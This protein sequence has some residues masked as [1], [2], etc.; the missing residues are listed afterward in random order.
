MEEV[1]DEMAD[2][3]CVSCR[4]TLGIATVFSTREDEGERSARVASEELLLALSP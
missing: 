2:V 1:V 4:P 3:S